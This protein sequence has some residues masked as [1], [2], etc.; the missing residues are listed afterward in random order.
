MTKFIKRFL[1]KKL[2]P[3]LLLIFLLPLI[4]TQC[5]AV[6]FFFDRH[7]EK[8]VTRFSNI[9]SN[10]INLI[11]NEYEK[12]GINR[13]R[14]I[15]ARLNISFFILKELDLE[16][17]RKYFL[18][19]K[20]EE[21]IIS[22]IGEDIILEF[23]EDSIKFYQKI[24]DK[25]IFLIF[26]KK[27]L[28]SE[29]PIILFL[30]IITS[31]LFLTFIAFLFLRI[32]IRAIQRLAKSAEEFGNGRKK[33]SKFKPEGALEIRSAGSAFIKMKQRIND[34]IS[35]K[36]NFL[37]GISHDLGTILTRIKLRLELID[38]QNE[39]KDIKKDIMTMQ[40]FLR[41]YLDYSEKIS[42]NRFD[43]INIIS[44]IKDIVS[45][46][47]HLKK[48]TK[49]IYKTKIFFKTDKNCLHRIILNLCENASR[50]SENIIVTSSLNSSILKIDIDDDGPGIP[51][52]QKR[53]IFKPF[54][55]IDN[56]RN[57][58]HSG[59]GLGLSIA[60]ELVKTLNGRIELSDSKK[61]KGS[62][63]S[64]KLRS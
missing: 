53:K 13:A 39:I 3:R 16:N 27:Y 12:N 42:V 55:K 1:P 30:W 56:S 25:Y 29:T 44:L 61:L 28:Y 33:V 20:I 22:R 11:K 31:S 58:N 50:Y 19:K 51:E 7:W 21:S 32:Q 8:I 26:P 63:F 6:I 4:F 49:I 23:E 34:Y 24:D 46:S 17:E 45:N 15:S 41:E 40:T 10:Q 57:L 43:E 18:K 35:Q 2:L 54:Y 5:I 62:N 52:G 59:T 47:K 48:K 36:T 9:A 14:E 38:D 37:S 60:N 64:I